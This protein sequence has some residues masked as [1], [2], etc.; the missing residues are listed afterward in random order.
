[1]KTAMMGSVLANGLDEKLV[2]CSVGSNFAKIILSM[3]KINYIWCIQ[4]YQCFVLHVHCIRR[5]HKDKT[6]D[7][8]FQNSPYSLWHCHC[9]NKGVSLSCLSVECFSVQTQL[10]ATETL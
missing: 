7:T 4:M 5:G 2:Q 10:T 3:F 6:H 8:T 9:Y 1:M